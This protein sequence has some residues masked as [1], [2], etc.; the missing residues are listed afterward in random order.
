MK[1]QLTCAG[2]GNMSRPALKAADARSLAEADG[3]QVGMRGAGMKRVEGWEDDYC[4][5]CKADHPR[6]YCDG[7]HGRCEHRAI[8]IM[9]RVNDPSRAGD[10]A[11]TA[12]TC[13]KHHGPIL[14]SMIVGGRKV[15]IEEAPL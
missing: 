11:V 15:L 2:C 9:V 8:Y 1:Y 4:A 14:R 5:T 3:W 10:P 12:R 7:W 13:G 6:T